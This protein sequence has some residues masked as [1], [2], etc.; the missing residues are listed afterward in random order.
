MGPSATALTALAAELERARSGAHE[1]VELDLLTTLR[2]RPLT[3][4]RGS[5]AE[6]TEEAERLLGDRGPSAAARLGLDEAVGDGEL[7]AVALAALARWRAHA[8]DP[9]ADRDTTEAARVV[10]RSVE[11]LLATRPVPVGI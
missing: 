8:E 10:V 9:F 1:I 2:R 7:R 5:G 3:A 4:R 11:G 6:L